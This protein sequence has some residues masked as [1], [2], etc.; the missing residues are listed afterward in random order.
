[1]VGRKCSPLRCKI[2]GLA[3]LFAQDPVEPCVKTTAVA[4]PVPSGK[5]RCPVMFTVSPEEFPLIRSA[6]DLGATGK[7]I[8]PGGLAK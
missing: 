8:L 2:Y 3:L 7:C 6:K 1:M 4:F 5:H